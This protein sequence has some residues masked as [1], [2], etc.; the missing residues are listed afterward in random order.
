MKKITLLLILLT[1]SFGYSQTVIED[2]ETGI[3][4]GVN[5]VSDGVT[6]AVTDITGD[7]PDNLNT[8]HMVS[9]AGGNPWQ[10]AQ[11]FFQADNLDL[12]TANKVVTVD[13]YSTSA[14]NMLAKAVDGPG[15][16]PTESAT[17]DSHT[18][19]GWETLSFDFSNNKDG[20][21]VASEVYGRI[22]FFP[23]WTGSGWNDPATTSVTCY[24]D[25]ITGIAAAPPETCS[26]G[27]QNQDETDIDCGGTICAPCAAPPTVAAPTPP[28][29]AAADVISIYSD[30]YTD[31]TIDNFDYG[32]CDGG[33]SNLAAAEVMIAGNP[34]QNYLGSGCQGIGFE[35]NRIDASTFTNLHFDFFTDE[36]SLIGKVFNIKLVDFAGTA[37]GVSGLEVNFNDGTSPAITTGSWISVD[38]DITAIGGMVGGNL[39]RSDIAQIHITSNLPNAW[40]DNLYLHKGTTLS[41]NE[42][43]TADF[44]VYPNPSNNV[45]N[46]KTSNTIMNSIQVFDV[47]GKQVISLNPNSVEAKIDASTLPTGLYFAKIATDSGI[48]SIKLIKN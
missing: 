28:A 10:N 9:T 34:T 4:A 48:N 45:W 23:L 14:F 3:T 26:D 24:V 19:S 42:F 30:A 47:L 41:A 31:I 7:T 46:V 11:L 25:N 29:R 6:T 22:L 2:F 8:G 21:A 1:C 32:E 13:V 36:T 15:G 38:V 37:V 44:S 5:W 43:E 35:T 16:I 12:S 20:S 33:V 27:I 39:T 18:G 17:D 40:Y